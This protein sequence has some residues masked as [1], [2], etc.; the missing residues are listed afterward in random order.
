MRKIIY[1]MLTL[2]TSLAMTS[3]LHDNETLFE[4]PAAQRIETEVTND[5]AL[6]ESA[7]NGWKLNLW[8]GEGY[9]EGGYTYLIKF[10]NGKASVSGEIANPTDV[11]TSSYDIIKDMGPV[12]TFNTHNEILHALATPTMA[13]DDG[14]QQD[15][16]FIIQR[17]TQDSIFLEG[18][19]WHNKMV[20]TRMDDKTNWAQYIASLQ[21]TAKSILPSFRYVNGTDTTDIVLGT[22]RVLRV[23]DGHSI[24]SISFSYTSDGIKLQSP[25]K[26]GDKQ[27]QV[28][29][30][31]KAKKTMVAQASASNVVFEKHLPKNYMYYEDFAGNYGLK[32]AYGTISVSLQPAGDG[33]TYLLKGLSADY[34]VKLTYNRISGALDWNSQN[35]YTDAKGNQF[36]L[37]AWGLKTQKGSFT[38]SPKAGFTLAKDIKATGTV[39]KVSTNDYFN[40]DS[41]VLVEFAGPASNDTYVG[42]ATAHLVHGNARMPF[43]S[44]MTKQ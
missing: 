28:L 39:L 8:A 23:S 34:D 44:T 41:Y 18:K 38:W 33:E 14:S 17:T 22:D 40:A 26:V 32:Y 3:C 16:E 13:D 25:I 24:N 37:C 43:L 10:K 36:W 7:T 30:Y 31:D 5:K 42:L 2:A 9:T 4:E 21:N 20:M 19:K 35:V 29:T 6:L 11:A 1:S 15:F 27:V 12:L